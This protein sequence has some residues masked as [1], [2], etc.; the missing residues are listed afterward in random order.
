MRLTILHT[1][2]IHGRQER[3]AQIATRV[4]Q[5]RAESP[6]SVL[7]LDGGDVEETTN[8]LSNVTKGA[9]MHRLLGCASCDAA[10]VGNACWLRYGAGVLADHARAAPYPLLLANFAPVAGPVPSALLGDVGVFGLTDPFR[11]LREGIEWGFEPL[12]ELEVARASSADLRRRGARLVVL[13]SHLG[14][15][16][17]EG[18][19]DDRR[20]AEQLQE[21]VDLIVGAHS[22]DLLPEGEWV[23]RVL[24]TQAGAFGDHVGRIEVADGSITA[25]VEEV[26]DDVEPSPL[27]VEEAV[28]VE[29]EVEGLLDSEVGSLES[30]LDA[31]WIA[32]ALRR[33][34]GAEVGLFSEGLSRGVLPPGRVTRRA[35]FKISETGANPAVTAMTGAQLA[36]LIE[37]A[38][39]PAFVEERPRSHR[40]RSRGRLHVRGVIPAELDPARS[41]TVAGTDWE[42]SP[43]GG[44]VRAEWGLR[45]RFDFPTIVREAI[46]EE[47]TTAAR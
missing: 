4:R 36:D 13:L 24:I 26:A 27:V 8:E 9:A 7:Y 17:P 41:Y 19:W 11:E 43:Y 46:E 21:D 28:R 35:L 47:L 14:L 5:A 16:K 15:E 38:G 44:Y 39:D 25:S 29:A 33:R 10:T 34:M 20:I 32:D 18:R 37:R 22:H 31:D 2:D 23:G 30:P 45:V 40:G 42:L 3:I 12:D 1:N 6:H